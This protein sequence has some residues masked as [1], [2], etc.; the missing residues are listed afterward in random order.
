MHNSKILALII[1]ALIAWG[2]ATMVL[3]N[4]L[5]TSVPANQ[6]TFLT[7]RFTTWISVTFCCVIVGLY[8]SIR[9]N[10]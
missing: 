8:L 3:I 2:G 6:I 7:L 1:I 5:F 10:K 9:E 4:A